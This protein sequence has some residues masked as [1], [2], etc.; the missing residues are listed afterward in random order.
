MPETKGRGLDDASPGQHPSE[1]F[2]LRED[3]G[4]RKKEEAHN[5]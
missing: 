2:P 3:R 1:D 5:D 4:R